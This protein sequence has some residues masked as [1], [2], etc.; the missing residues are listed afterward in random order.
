MQ[1]RNS[2]WYTEVLLKSNDELWIETMRLPR[3]AVEALAEE[4][5]EELQPS[6]NC[7]RTPVPLFKRVCIS[8]Y[9]LASCCEYRV[10]AEQFGVSKVTVFRCVNAFCVALTAHQAKYIQFP[11]DEE[12][13]SIADRIE[14]RHKYPQAFAALDGSHIAIN[15]PSDGLA[16]Y[17]NRKMYAS[18]VLQ[19]LVD[20]RFMFRDVSCKCPG[21]MHDSTVFSNSSLYGRLERHMPARDKF[22]NGI[23]VPL[24]ILGDPAYPLST[25]VIKGFVG[26]NLTPQQISFNVYHSSARMMVENAFGRLKARWR[27]VG[28][29]MDCNIELA[30]YVVM[31]CCCLHNICEQQKTAITQ[32]QIERAIQDAAE[33][34][35]QPH[36]DQRVE[37]SAAAIRNALKDHLATT[38]PLRTSIYH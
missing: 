33:L 16:D 30:P 23:S 35:P 8:L 27:T 13:A 36:A 31:A 29:R 38:Q 19:G 5:R 10:A 24:H 17:L 34:Q 1:D 2:T 25:K 7:I 15:P 14:Q 21:S 12:A 26:R 11:S 6:D 4:L 3:H 32:A 18:I 20:D 22:I 37:S 28:K 9:K